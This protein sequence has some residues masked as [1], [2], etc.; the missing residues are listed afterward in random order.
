M[1]PMLISIIIV[2]ALVMILLVYVVAH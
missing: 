2:G 1:K